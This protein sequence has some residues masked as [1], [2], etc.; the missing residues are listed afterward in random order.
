MALC[1]ASVG[2]D[3][4]YDFSKLETHLQTALEEA[5][6]GNAVV[7]VE[8]LSDG[9]VYTFEGGS[10]K[11]TTK[12]EIAS[13]TKWLAGF[14]M[15]KLAEE[16]HLRLD[17]RVDAHLAAFADNQNGN[18]TLRQAFGMTSGLLDKVYQP[19]QRRLRTLKQTVNEIAQNVPQTYTPGTGLAYD[20]KGM[21]TAGYVAEFLTDIA[22]R[23]LAEMYLYE[24]LGMRDTSWDF[25][26]SLNPGIAGGAASTPEDYMK[27]LRTILRKGI[28]DDGVRVLSE[29][30]I[31]LMFTSQTDGL[32]IL[33][34]PEELWDSVVPGGVDRKDYCF[35]TWT[36]ERDPDTRMV[37]AIASPGAFKTFPWIDRKRQACGIIFLRTEAGDS[38]PIAPN[39]Q[40]MRLIAEAL[41]HAFHPSSLRVTLEDDSKPSIQWEGQAQ[42]QV[43]WDMI[44][45]TDYGSSS[46]EEPVEIQLTQ[47][48]PVFYRIRPV[49]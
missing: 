5:Y 46:I 25:Y 48:D 12:K 47:H 41:D 8:T 3:A 44:H 27:F 42:P 49:N 18:F 21:Q 43:S 1:H 9:R 20:G 13:A 16:G 23:D 11:T 26:G 15:L 38:A 34:S 22:W 14:I 10:F 33:Y 19:E 40:A 6:G 30:S 4:I 37:T 35:G 36:W 7:L 2:G 31:D 17:D 29:D 32:P 45:W 28:N 24:P 39:V